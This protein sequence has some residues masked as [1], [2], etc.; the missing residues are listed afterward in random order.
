MLDP[1]IHQE[2]RLR[3]VAFL[4]RNGEATFSRVCVELSLTPGNVGAHI[5]KLQ[6]AGYLTQ[7]Q[8][9]TPVGFE[10]KFF[11]TSDGISAFRAYLAALQELLAESQTPQSVRTAA[12]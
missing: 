5:A 2:S 7:R 10:R 8:V 9:L 1:V 3:L 12:E 11:L 6:E 4:H